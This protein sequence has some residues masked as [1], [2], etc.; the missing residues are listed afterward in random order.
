MS[1]ARTLLLAVALLGCS[2]TN[3]NFCEGRNPND[4]CSEPPVDGTDLPTACT[5]DEQCMN[6]A[7][8]HV[9]DTSGAE[10][11]CVE[12][13]PGR[14]ASCDGAKPV[15]DG[16]TKSCV[17]CTAHAQCIDSEA[18][19]PTGACADAAEVAYARP[20]GT[21]TECTKA[22]P[23]GTLD[24]A[25][26]ANRT[27]IK[28]VASG[29]APLRDTN[30]TTIDGKTLTILADPG[31]RMDI[32]VVDKTVLEIKN[33]ANV[34]IYDLTIA[35]SAGVGGNAHG[36]ALTSGV[37][38]V[39][40]ERVGVVDNAGGAGITV[41]GGNLTVRR[42]LFSN[43][44]GT[45]AIVASGGATIDVQDSTF[46]QNLGGG[47]RTDT[48]VLYKIVNNFIYRN[49]TDAT[50]AYGGASLGNLAVAT[51]RF[52]FN[53][54]VDNRAALGAGGVVCQLPAFAAPNNIVARNFV[55]NSATPTNQTTA[56]GCTFPTSRVQADVAGLA[57]TSPDTAPFN[58]KIGTGSTAIDQAANADI[59]V[60][61][62]G[63]VRPT[64]NGKDIGADELN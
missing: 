64:G 60:D 8:K 43:N 21:G 14:A 29:G 61:F 35:G 2:K 49:G 62:E 18:C 7:D 4:N 6:V 46:A 13:L 63:D 33:N 5:K 9:C 11:V 25:I 56:A 45:G 55:A 12:C 42:S 10:G 37:P 34:Q 47:I 51:N 15:C 23:C 17:G 26:D 59:T 54:V 36:I 31:V 50:S 39:R 30:T 44:R 16:G 20:G 28:V 22:D 41:L 19:L 58:Y 32:G 27:F 1:S 53:T 3:T 52:E 48:N 38:T 40:L 24:D 57:F